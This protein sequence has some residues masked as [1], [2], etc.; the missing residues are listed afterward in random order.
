[1]DMKMDLYTAIRINSPKNSLRKCIPP[2]QEKNSF[3]P[4]PM[5]HES[6]WLAVFSKKMKNFIQ[7][8]GLVSRETN[9][10]INNAV[11][12]F[13]GFTMFILG[14]ILITKCVYTIFKVQT[15]EERQETRRR[16]FGRTARVVSS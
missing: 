4:F 2:P 15:E 9:E 11:S 1:M 6:N 8:E 16:K 10:K 14:L 13:L 7:L 3:N 12:W 5:D